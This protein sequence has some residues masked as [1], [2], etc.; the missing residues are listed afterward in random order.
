[1]NRIVLKSLMCLAVG[2]LTGGAPATEI[3]QALAKDTHGISGSDAKSIRTVIEAQLD[4]FAKDDAD[5][6]FSYAAPP[7]Q[8]MFGSPANFLRMVKTGYPVVYRPVSV[9]FLKPE[10]I[11]GEIMQA[12]QLSDQE[13]QVWVAHYR[14]QRQNNRRWL[15]NGCQLEKS[16]ARVT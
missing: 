14:M 9:T 3:A 10:V 13:G 6:A 12:V 11:D 5:Q 1:M 16:D 4:A 7:I 2:L 15:I 8:T